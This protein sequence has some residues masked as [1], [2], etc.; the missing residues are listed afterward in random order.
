MPWTTPSL[1]DVRTNNADYIAGKLQVPILPNGEVRV[2]ADANAGNAHLN[3]QYLDWQSEQYLPD[4]AEK[5]LLDRH[6]N[7]WLVNADGSRGR[8]AATYARGTATFTGLVAG[9]VLPQVSQL[10][11]GTLTFETT[12]AVTVAVGPTPVTIRAL[13]EA[14]PAISPPAR[15]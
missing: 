7:I 3:L 5:E 12:A 14:R 10:T 11:S 8:K 4:T 13:V 15:R 6:G 9:T 2:L 1:T